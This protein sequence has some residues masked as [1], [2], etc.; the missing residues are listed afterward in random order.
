MTIGRVFLAGLVGLSG[1]VADEHTSLD[2]TTL[3]SREESVEWR[4]TVFDYDL[5]RLHIQEVNGNFRISYTGTLGHGMLPDTET[6]TKSGVNPGVD[7]E[8][9]ITECKVRYLFNPALPYY[10]TQSNR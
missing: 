6:T 7:A 5:N 9:I 4:C 10:T 1:V 2:F 8:E 3:N